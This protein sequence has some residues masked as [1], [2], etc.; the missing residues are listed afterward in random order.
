METKRRERKKN[1]KRKLGD[2]VS[3]NKADET[4]PVHLIPEIF[5]S[6]IK[7]LRKKIIIKKNQHKNNKGQ[8]T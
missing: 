6:E 1:G 7:T 8:K 4:E 3:T 5:R 2:N